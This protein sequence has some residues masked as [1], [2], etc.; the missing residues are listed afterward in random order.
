MTL[1]TSRLT[2]ESVLSFL[3]R[4]NFLF[5]C[6]HDLPFASTIIGNDTKNW[7]C[8]RCIFARAI[9]LVGEESQVTLLVGWCGNTSFVTRWKPHARALS[10]LV[11]SFSNYFLSVECWLSNY[12]IIYQNH[13]DLK[14]PSVWNARLLQCWHSELTMCAVDLWSIIH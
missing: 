13:M 10:F 7:N 8:Q 1:C 6:F 11:T 12:N 4:T 14:P 3:L 2:Q 9:S 5:V